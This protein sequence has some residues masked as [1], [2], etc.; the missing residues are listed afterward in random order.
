MNNRRK[1]S[2]FLLFF[3]YLIK[4]LLLYILVF[5]YEINF[6]INIYNNLPLR[7]NRGLGIGDW[8]LGNGGWAQESM[9]KR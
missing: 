5:L 6:F 1:F 3:L 7:R 2:C 9:P 8:G 4:L